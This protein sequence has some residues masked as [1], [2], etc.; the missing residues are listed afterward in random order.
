MTKKQTVPPARL[1]R[2]ISASRHDVPAAGWKCM[3][4]PPSKC[5]GGADHTWKEYLMCDQAEA[6]RAESLGIHMVEVCQP[7][8]LTLMR[9]R[10][11]ARLWAPY[12]EFSIWFRR[13]VLP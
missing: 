13:A 2:L 11:R 5:L 8:G 12:T 3:N 4:T 1:K 9:M 10:S 7:C 6:D